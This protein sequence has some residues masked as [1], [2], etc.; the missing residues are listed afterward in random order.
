MRTIRKRSE[1]PGAA[2]PEQSN[3]EP[4]PFNMERLFNP[5]YIDHV[6]G[7]DGIFAKSFPG[8]EPRAGQIELARAVNKAIG[9]GHKLIAEAPTGTGKS[10]A[11][12][13]PAIWHN[14]NDPKKPRTI[15][16][17]ANIALQEQLVTKDL[18]TLRKLLP[19]P[20]AFTLAKG[21]T[22]YGCHDRFEHTDEIRNDLP[23]LALQLADV[24]AWFRETQT[25]DVSELPFVPNPRLWSELSMGSDQCK[26][27]KCPFRD[28]CYVEAAKKRMEASGIIVTNYHLFFADMIVRASTDGD[29]S[30]LP[31]AAS[32]IFDE[33]HKATEIARDFIGSK[34]GEGVIRR[35]V[36]DANRTVREAGTKMDV[37]ALE[38]VE[39]FGAECF[40]RALLYRKSKAYKARLKMEGEFDPGR[41][42]DAL[43]R[44]A[45]NL[46]ETAADGRLTG[47]SRE[48]IRKV[49]ERAERRADE[50]ANVRDLR[51]DEL[52]VY[53]IDEERTH[54]G[55][56]RAV[57]G[58][59]MIDPSPVLRDQV[60]GR[61]AC[62]VATSATMATGGSFEHV[63]ADLGCDEFEELTAASPF[64][65]SRQALLVCP[66]TMCE[67]NDPEFGEQA[68]DAVV[69]AIELARGRTLALFTS[70][71]NLDTAHR[72]T[73]ARGFPFRILR[74]GDL[75]RTMLIE[76][77]RR[78]VSSVLFGTASF[79][80]GVDVQ[81]DA[82][83]CVV[84]D[85]LPFVTPD[86][87]IM[88]AISS[89]QR[90]WFKRWMLPRAVIAFRQGFGRLIRTVNDRGV[91]VVLDRRILDKPYGKIFV[92]GTG[93][94][95][96]TRRIGDIGPF[97]STP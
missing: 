60:F 53:Y 12:A 85:R 13:V 58:S 25:G 42:I 56:T 50:L 10:I 87:P 37:A 4:G 89:R 36:R 1:A 81:G 52:F 73:L 23:D 72:A 77:F 78:D 57:I 11:Y 80:E 26:G 9:D 61:Y 32:V 97:L 69:E 30:I 34:I 14:A 21:R 48:A 16:V 44:L 65:M 15:I 70:Y 6:F 51:D 8:Y 41:V 68:A 2:S 67:P 49:A 66:S 75:P 64:D 79:W 84:I 33:A 47:E 31:N 95:A 45:K 40:E 27:R 83:S 59:K 17:T 22:N 43:N 93:G 3:E 19:W 62:V 54:N 39:A 7:R 88:D 20:F 76:E 38:D 86:D 55:G 91:V 96:M 74:Q 82:L 5:A 24:I 71:R 63:A 90:D 28:R 29:A 18:P 46:F 94:A 35:L 92:R